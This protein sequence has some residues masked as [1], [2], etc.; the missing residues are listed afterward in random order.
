M[1]STLKY[2]PEIDGLRA[3]AVT[4]VILFHANFISGGFL[5][6][7]IFFV[8]SGY[9]ISYQIIN[10]IKQHGKFSFLNFYKRRAKRILPVLFVVKLITLALGM[11]FFNPSNLIDLSYSA[12]S[13]L[14]FVSNFYFWE[15]SL[16]YNSQR[17]IFYPL[18]HTWSLSVEE[19]FYI[20][21]PL[22]LFFFQ[23]KR[24]ILILI[25]ISTISFILANILS[26]FFDTLNFYLIITRIWEFA[27]GFFAA[28]NH[29]YKKR[30]NFLEKVNMD[31]V[32]LALIL[33]LV[34]CIFFYDKNFKHPSIFT[35][36]P[37]FSTFL[38]INCRS[39]SSI[40]YKLL[41]LKPIV[42]LGLIS[43]SLYLWHYP[44]FSFSQHLELIENNYFRK[45]LI[46]LIIILLS[47]ISYYF[48]EK[49]FRNKKIEFKKVFL[50][51]IFN[52]IL[53]L[54]IAN[55]TI[56]KK[57][58][59]NR[60]PKILNNYFI[61]LE[62]NQKKD[63]IIQGNCEFDF[64]NNKKV[65]LIGDSH[66]QTLA[67]DLIDR[68]KDQKLS[69]FVSTRPWCYYFP[70]FELVHKNNLKKTEC[71][72]DYFFELKTRI[73]NEEDS[74]I[75]L[76]GRLPV[77]LNGDFFDNKE[78]GKEGD[79]FSRKFV[80]K[81]KDLTLE[82]SFT[83]EVNEIL[84]KNKVILIYPIPE[85][86]W[87]VPDKIMSNKIKRLIFGAEYKDVTTSYDVYRKRT[88]SSFVLLDELEHKN[89]IRFY[90]HEI[91][92]KKSRCFTHD[93]ENIYYHDD[94]H[95]SKYGA[96]LLN[97]SIIKIITNLN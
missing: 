19:Q 12:I 52:F 40:V 38:L 83:F 94:D 5:G 8:I 39:R 34:L 32:H 10:E 55:L 48:I 47:I 36:I 44:I 31:L 95:L 63:C 33:I 90:P 13:S 41:S 9:L 81:N 78:G 50:F 76:A 43:Y 59:P 88:S 84:K 56:I 23:G 61:S 2:R 42:F 53:I 65:F 74:I 69:Y 62:N 66:M 14:F 64:A 73:N 15:T 18:L 49:K 29:F 30:N 67:N 86:G 6:V 72:E 54:I 77:Y 45:I 28:H 57:G 25:S 26:F 51:L 85:V 92:C 75:I 20:L 22:F 11:I 89:L 71:N 91:F 70:N 60:L 27:F 37:V 3:I 93:N 16:D 4:S 1:I 17:A 87:R 21:F 80:T 97:D 58:F 79:K 82:K 24:L 68:I 7:D 35:L 96:K 46:G